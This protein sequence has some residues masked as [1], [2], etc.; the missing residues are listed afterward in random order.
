MNKFCIL[1]FK[2]DLRIVDNQTL[3]NALNSELPV[4]PVFL[5]EPEYLAHPTTDFR[6]IRFGYESVI[7]LKEHLKNIGLELQILKVSAIDFFNWAI[8]SEGLSAVYSTEE[9]G[10]SWSYQRDKLLGQKLKQNQ[11]KWI[12]TPNNGVVRG[13]KSRN[14]WVKS[15]LEVMEKPI[16]YTPNLTVRPCHLKIP[17]VEFNLKLQPNFMHSMQKGGEDLAYRYLNGF[18]K[19]RGKGYLKTISKPEASRKKCS[20]ISAYLAWGCISSKQVWKKTKMAIEEGTIN[21]R[22]G[23]AFLSRLRW[24]CHFIQKFESECR[25]EFEAINRGYIGFYVNENI[26]WINAWKSGRTG[27]PL[28]DASMRCLIE[29]GY[30]NFRMR[31]M[32]VSVLTHTL[33]QDWR[34]A[35]DYLGKLFLDFEPGIHYP[36]IQMQAGIVGTHI[37]R[38]YNPLKQAIEHDSEAIFI[39]KWLPELKKL[40]VPLVFNPSEITPLEAK[41]YDFKIGVDYPLPICNFNIENRVNSERLWMMKNNPYVKKEAK[42]ILNKHSTPNRDI[43]VNINTLK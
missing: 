42:R 3:I 37:I 15:W 23:A 28:V 18:L 30:L 7:N 14:N 4:L 43:T 27:W 2:R 21:K 34:I 22:D 41:F 29:T 25:M 32:L 16:A 9:I 10:L 8:Q 38:S 17:F 1:W 20:R 11:V 26:D 35:A 36:Q 12:E 39:K 5:F 40:P 33:N 13:L 24:R 31:A 19:G 6:H